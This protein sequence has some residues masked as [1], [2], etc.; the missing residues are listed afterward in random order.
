MG[1][2]MRASAT[3]KPA[4]V[5]VLYGRMMLA[6]KHTRMHACLLSHATHGA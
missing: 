4:K 1:M 3:G 6:K 5:V 2:G